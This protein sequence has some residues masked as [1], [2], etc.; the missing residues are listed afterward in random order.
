M[1]SL[2]IE[3]VSNGWIVR[4]YANGPGWPSCDPPFMAVFTTIE[5]LQKAIP[6]MLTE[7]LKAPGEK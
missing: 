2:V 3:T 7:E 5:E 6:T 1:K 4:P